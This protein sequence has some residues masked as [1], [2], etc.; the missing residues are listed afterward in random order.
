MPAAID[1]LF[2]KMLSMGA[3]D[4]HIS[5]GYPVMMR[6]KGDLVPVTETVLAADDTRKLLYEILSA[7]ER[8]TFD[9]EHDLD[10]AYAFGTKARF[11]ANYLAKTTGVGAVF[12]TIPS[13]VLTLEEL[14][15]P[16]AIRDLAKRRVG[17]IL[18]TGPTGSGKSTTLAAVLDYIN[19]TRAGHILT[20]EDPVEFVH[21]PQ[22]CQITHREVGRDVPS[23]AD[24]IRSAGRENADVVLVGELR[25]A[26]TMG[27]ALQMAGAGVFG[28][29][30]GAYQFGCCHHR[31]LCQ[32]VSGGASV[33]GTWHARR[34]A[35]RRRLT[36][37]A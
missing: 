29:C 32:R 16:D 25:G 18:V 21:Q 13:K 6:M 7:S 28:V 2:D 35:D 12:R 34:N 10:F 22:R 8:E 9:S 5:P 24:A 33:G 14:R 36:A 37:A 31:P 26:E 4:L 20:I 3:S 23:F 27:L 30:H 15:L 1:R 17:M 19:K 11:R